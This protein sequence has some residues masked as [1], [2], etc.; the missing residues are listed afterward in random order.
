MTSLRNLLTTLLAAMGPWALFW[1]ALGDSSFLPLAQAVDVL[2][3]AQALLS[4]EQA[5]AGAALA[6]AGSTLGCFAAYLAARRGG[7]RILEKYVSPPRQR[8]LQESFARHGAWQLILQTMVPLPLPM[9]LSILGA[10][11]FRMR[12]WR[13]LG[14]VLLARA[15]RYLGLAFVTLTFGEHAILTFEERGWPLV[16]LIL[17]GTAA[18]MAWRMFRPSRAATHAPH[19]LPGATRNADCLLDTAG[20]RDEHGEKELAEAHAHG[21][22]ANPPPP[23][24]D[25]DGDRRAGCLPPPASRPLDSGSP[26]QSLLHLLQRI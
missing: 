20:L 19:R 21:V 6:V 18:W 7:R 15:V 2:V 22:G 10:G 3:V 24:R 23:A 25:P 26:L 9:R 17:A 5:Y 14:A 8:K 1:I 11:V 16:S 12:P 13:F 4:P